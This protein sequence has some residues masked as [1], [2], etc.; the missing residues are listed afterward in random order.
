MFVT[1]KPSQPFES[2]FVC[3]SARQDRLD[4]AAGFLGGE[5]RMRQAG[6]FVDESGQPDIATFAAKQ[7]AMFSLQQQTR[8]PALRQ[9]FHRAVGGKSQVRADRRELRGIITRVGMRGD[10]KTLTSKDSAG[11]DAFCHH[12]KLAQSVLQGGAAVWAL[13]HASQRSAEWLTRRSIDDASAP[14]KP[15]LPDRATAIMFFAGEK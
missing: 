14:L 10:G 12:G 15:A 2:A 4:V 9:P 3:S 8:Q 5:E 13:H 11:D 1:T 7:C 6:I